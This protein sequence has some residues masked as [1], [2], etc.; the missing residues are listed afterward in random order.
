MACIVFICT[1]YHKIKFYC[2]GLCPQVLSDLGSEALNSTLEEVIVK[3]RKEM[4]EEKEE[5]EDRRVEE[6]A[7]DRQRFEEMI[8]RRCEERMKK[9]I[10]EKNLKEREKVKVLERP[11]V[12]GPKEKKVEDSKKSILGNKG[13]NSTNQGSMEIFPSACRS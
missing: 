6:A 8:E 10:E 2:F 7:L 3:K 13:V 9:W 12:E 4:I 1:V 5:E 11:A